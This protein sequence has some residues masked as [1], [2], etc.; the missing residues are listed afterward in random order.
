LSRARDLKKIKYL[1][2]PLYALTDQNKKMMLLSK[3]FCDRNPFPGVLHH[4]ERFP[5]FSGQAIGDNFLLGRKERSH[6]SI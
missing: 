6:H 5:L 1:M 2:T 4:V 3:F